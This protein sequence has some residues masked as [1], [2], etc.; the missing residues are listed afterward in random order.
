MKINLSNEG[1]RLSENEIPVDECARSFVALKNEIICLEKGTRMNKKYSS[2]KL[3]HI[4]ERMLKEKTNNEISY[5][6]NGEF[7]L[8]MSQCG[9][10]VE[11]CSCLSKNAYFNLKDSSLKRFEN[12]Y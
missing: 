6:S 2:Y 7:I 10:R 8:A 4:F 3:K 1:I 5:I 11:R 12:Y 9:F